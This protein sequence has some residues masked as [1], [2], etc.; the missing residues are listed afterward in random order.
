MKETGLTITSMVMASRYRVT[1]LRFKE[2]GLVT[3]STAWLT[4]PRRAEANKPLSS[5]MT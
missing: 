2:P 5:R 3:D 1:E 4:S